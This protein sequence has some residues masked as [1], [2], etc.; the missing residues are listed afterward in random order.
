[1]NHRRITRIL[2]AIL[3]CALLIS[4]L[5]A[6]R[7]QQ[8][9]AAPLQ[10]VV[11]DFVYFGSFEHT[12][13][14]WEYENYRTPIKWRVMEIDTAGIATLLS[15][16]V[17]DNRP[18]NGKVAN[19]WEGTDL[20]KWL[21]DAGLFN[22]I[23]SNNKSG[24]F[25]SIESSNSVIN[26]I[27][28]PGSTSTVFATLP[29]QAQI[30]RWTSTPTAADPLQSVLP[31]AAGTYRISGKSGN[32]AGYWLRGDT[33]ENFNGNDAWG[34]NAE[35]SYVTFS[36]DAKVVSEGGARPAYGV[37][38]VI[39]IN[40]KSNSLIKGTGNGTADM[41]YM[42][43]DM[44]PFASNVASASVDSNILTLK[45]SKEFVIVGQP[46]AT[47]FKVTQN[48][49]NVGIYNIEWGLTNGRERTMT[50][51]LNKAFTS[52]ESG[53]TISYAN[54]S[55]YYVIRL[56]D[57]YQYVG[58]FNN[59][60][61]S[62][63]TNKRELRM[64]DYVFF[65]NEY[66]NESILWQV[67]GDSSQTNIAYR[68]LATKPVDAKAWG[69]PPTQ[70]NTSWEQS[71]LRAWL[72][73]EDRGF[74]SVFAK[75]R[76][77]M[78]VDDEGKEFAITLTDY[79]TLIPTGYN[80]PGAAS[81]IQIPSAEELGYLNDPTYRFTSGFNTIEGRAIPDP[82][83]A[84]SD[85][86]TRTVDVAFP[87]SNAWFMG[88]DGSFNT[89]SRTNNHG[90]RPVI[91]F[92]SGSV[93]MKTGF[94][95]LDAPYYFYTQNDVTLWD[96]KKVATVDNT[97]PN[98]ITIEFT[99]KDAVFDMLDG[100]PSPSDFT[101]TVGN[102]VV[103][104]LSIETNPAQHKIILIMANEVRPYANQRVLVSYTMNSYALYKVDFPAYI[105][106]SDENG[107]L[108]PPPK[109]KLQ[110][111]KD[112]ANLS[113]TF[114][115]VPAD[116]N[117]A[118]L[119]TKY[120]TN[121]DEKSN[122]LVPSFTPEQKQ[123][124]LRVPSD[125]ADL[126]ILARP[127]DPD[128]QV[129]FKSNGGG[130]ITQIGDEQ[131]NVSV[132]LKISKTAE[133]ITTIDITVTAQ[134]GSKTVYR[135]TVTRGKA[136][137]DASLDF[138]TVSPGTL[139]QKSNDAEGFLANVLDYYVEINSKQTSVEITAT[140]VFGTLVS[141]DKDKNVQSGVPKI[142]DLTNVKPGTS[143]VVEVVVAAEN[144]STRIY[145]IEFRRQSTDNT[146]ASLT[147][148][149]PDTR[150]Q[151][152]FNPLVMEYKLYYP[153]SVSQITLTPTLPKGSTAKVSVEV[154]G[155][156]VIEP[157]YKVDLN[158]INSETIIRVIVTPSDAASA[159]RVYVLTIVRSDSGTIPDT[160]LDED[161][162][163]SNFV[164]HPIRQTFVNGIV[165]SYVDS[166]V[167]SVAIAA[168]EAAKTKIIYLDVEVPEKEHG[169]GYL[170]NFDTNTINVLK[171]SKKITIV[172]VFT[173]VGNMW[174]D[175]PTIRSLRAVNGG[176][177]I[178]MIQQTFKYELVGDRPALK[179]SITAAGKNVPDL[180]THAVLIDIP[181]PRRYDEFADAVMTV[182]AN[183]DGTN[184]R[185][186]K[187]SSYDERLE[188]VRTRT[189]TFSIFAVA[190]NFKYYEDATEHWSFP[191]VVYLGARDIV[192]GTA[193][194]IYFPNKLVT[195]AEFMKML[196]TVTDDLTY[197]LGRRGT[198]S[199]VD[200]NRW[201]YDYVNW[202]Y[203]NNIVKGYPDG[204]FGVD[205]PITR[206]EMA[207]IVYRFAQLQKKA[208][209]QR[210]PN[211]GKFPDDANIAKWA[212]E[213]VY[214]LAGSMVLV[215]RDDGFDPKANAT[216]GEAAKVVAAYMDATLLLF[217]Y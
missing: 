88:G 174:L 114:Q 19:E 76:I 156:S 194:E 125:V 72:N 82:R 127:S 36:S 38:P 167:A 193:P 151:Y 27:R 55:N 57:G 39:Q 93:F 145:K 184:V 43:L 172:R 26:K 53:I 212:Q 116:Y 68:L 87:S 119:T 201:F 112:F 123:Y 159:T 162:N 191:N 100:R 140:T 16:H 139:I 45:F 108:I 71:E 113:A 11:G 178:N 181:Y 216:R 199:D 83:Q 187:S 40:T 215:G 137:A 64:G 69:A 118:S 18:M 109:R 148:D 142:V 138:L 22:S 207:V 70:Q 169:F 74:M 126:E 188:L 195:R 86:W 176:V 32:Q 99:E 141:I 168:A 204:S 47:D 25:T 92:M 94:G 135:I 171:D 205:R 80:R 50:L 17:I 121:T 48:G 147:V 13:G 124:T 49:E 90:I 73:D 65:G 1:M 56:V 136:S 75:P 144:G 30:E 128:A 96:P 37:R 102:R 217:D 170:T 77:K 111:L 91:A 179:V 180:G 63:V 28:L 58:G 157:P 35:G 78:F 211:V 203:A 85:I 79:K 8:A 210:D 132:P 183:D 120:T 155:G 107:N 202:G 62:N 46:K 150:K 104:V 196:G 198:F 164:I 81:P 52:G 143:R 4:P 9:Q 117:L 59:V 7:S 206:E 153:N 44:I 23:P 154:E 101:V 42:M 31:T 173:P 130:K 163:S 33:Q 67:V 129:T 160:G 3:I 2:S 165:T 133:S 208:L 110:I 189:S 209:P 34:V 149:P 66:N 20:Q 12:T 134:D 175:V 24:N 54:T 200:P 192:N 161:S 131:G 182:H 10:L 41:P 190:Y 185:L 103:P 214:A 5:P 177:T 122:T 152:K 89:D 213:A 60:T 115:S 98:R 95:T 61:V 6:G 97:S 15:W 186:M 158:G 51:R 21:N 146:L 105:P 197:D 14:M 29:S 84:P 106:S 166:D